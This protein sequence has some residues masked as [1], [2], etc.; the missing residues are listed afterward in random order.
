MDTVTL[1]T[2]RNFVEIGRYSGYLLA[3]NA[4]FPPQSPTT[5][6]PELETQ[7]VQPNL[8]L[9]HSVDETDAVPVFQP[10]AQKVLIAVFRK[11]MPHSIDY[12]RTLSTYA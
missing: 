10:K 8:I 6:Q 9:K 2:I 4:P 5:R 11:N 3:E 7:Q 12:P 1:M